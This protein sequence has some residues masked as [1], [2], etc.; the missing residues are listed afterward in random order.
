[1][2]RQDSST[3]CS[4]NID[5]VKNCDSTKILKYFNKLKS[6]KIYNDPIT[7]NVETN[8]PK[9]IINNDKNTK[10]MENLLIPSIDSMEEISNTVGLNVKNIEYNE[11][12]ETYSSCSSSE[13]TFNSGNNESHKSEKINIFDEAKIKEIKNENNANSEIDHNIEATEKLNN[14]SIINDSSNENVDIEK[15]EKSEDKDNKNMLLE[16]DNGKNINEQNKTNNN[17]S[18]S[19]NNTV[20]EHEKKNENL[21]TNENNKN[22]ETKKLNKTQNIEKKKKQK[23]IDKINNELAKEEKREQLKNT[24]NSDSESINNEKQENENKNILKK[25]NSKTDKKDNNVKGKKKN[26]CN[27]DDDNNEVNS[28]EEMNS[29]KI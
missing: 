6:T 15:S 11:I 5:D 25:K 21:S 14:K 19:E 13:F 24:N 12:S 8:I 16:K 26:S 18:I 28:H 10:Y 17:N 4:E 29:G 22:E 7:E 23:L 20:T 27:Q 2:L 3:S 9:S 1:M